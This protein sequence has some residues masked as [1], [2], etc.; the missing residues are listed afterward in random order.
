MAPHALGHLNQSAREVL[1]EAGIVTDLVDQLD[2]GHD[3]AGVVRCAELEDR[4]VFP[5]HLD[6]ALDRVLQVEVEEV[7]QHGHAVRARKIRYVDHGLR[8]G[9]SDSFVVGLDARG[10]LAPDVFQEA[11]TCFEV[12]QPLLRRFG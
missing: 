5:C 11:I 12:G 8:G 6:Q 3:D 4:P 1:V 9:H 7:S 2:A 10:R